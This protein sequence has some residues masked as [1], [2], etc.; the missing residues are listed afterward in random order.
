MK[1]VIRQG[2]F[3]TN[4]SSV[5]TITICTKEEY[6]K[7]ID[8]EL[9]YDDLTEKLVNKNT[10]DVN[11]K[12]RYKTYEN[13]GD[14]FSVYQEDYTSPNGEEYCAFGYYGYDG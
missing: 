8:G 11:H 3:E 5:H 14:N 2:V 12:Y 10:V 9:I 6:N 13:F 1:R 7:W 4:S